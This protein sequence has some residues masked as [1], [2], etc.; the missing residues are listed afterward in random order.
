MGLVA[1]GHT[2]NVGYEDF[3]EPDAQYYQ[4]HFSAVSHFS[5]ADFNRRDAFV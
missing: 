3:R 4:G 2:G 5:R 1:F